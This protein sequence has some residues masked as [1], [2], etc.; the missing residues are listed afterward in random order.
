MAWRLAKSLEQLRKQ[1]NAQ[2]PLRGKGSDGTI[3]DQAHADRKSDHNPDEHG[4]VR[5][6]DLTHDPAHGFDSYKFANLML[7]KQ[8]PRID[9][10]ISNRRIG[11]GPKGVQP[12]VWRKYTGKNPH[13]HHVHFSVIGGV[14]GAAGDSAKPWDISGMTLTADAKNYVAPLPTLR[15]GAAGDLVRKLQTALHVV[16]DGN[17]GPIT[18]AAVRDVQRKNDLIVDGIVGPMTWAAIAPKGE[19]G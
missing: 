11:S 15:Q 2:W 17:F 5:A 7:A 19:V 18:A 3:G 9:Y 16:A 6:L 14:P 12:G 13:D 8:D 1:V 10:I 4:I